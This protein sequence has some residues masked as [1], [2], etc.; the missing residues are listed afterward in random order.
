MTTPT[1]TPTPPWLSIAKS[2]IGVREIPGAP[3]HPTIARWLSQL[4]AWWTDDETPWCGVA[5]A[6]FV[7]EAGIPY[8]KAFYRAKAWATWGVACAPI[9]GCVVVFER[10]GGGHVAVLEGVT[11]SGKLVCVGGN[12]GDAVKMAVFDP[13]RVVAYRWPDKWPVPYPAQL[14]VVTYWIDATVSTNEA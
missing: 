14:P 8:P 4:R 3:T 10:A 2:Y 1:P 12:Q 6:A 5:M 13:A 7:N 9:R 11:A